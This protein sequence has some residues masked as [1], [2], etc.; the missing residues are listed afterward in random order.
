MNTKS[1]ALIPSWP[2]FSSW[3]SFQISRFFKWNSFIIIII[4]EMESKSVFFNKFN[5]EWSVK[6]DGRLIIIICVLYV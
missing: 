3:T 1:N 2:Q 4:W 6:N 5:H